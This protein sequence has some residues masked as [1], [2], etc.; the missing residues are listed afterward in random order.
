MKLKFL[1]LCACM[2]VL[3]IL[4]GG[5]TNRGAESSKPTVAPST[6]PSTEPSTEVTEPSVSAAVEHTVTLTNLAG[7]ALTKV[8]IRVYA[9]ATLTDLIAAG[10][11]D[12]SGQF[13]FKRV[14]AEGYVA[15][16]SKVPTGYGVASYYELTG[17]QTTVK[18]SSADISREELYKLQFRLG[19]AMPNFSVTGVDGTVYT[20]HELLETKKAVVLNFW[21]M[22][23]DPCKLEFPHIQQA[24]ANYSDEI[25][26]LAINPMDS[27]NQQIAQFM[28]EKGYTFPMMKGDADWISMFSISAFPLTVVIDRYGNICLTHTGGVPDTAT[29]E[30]MFEYFCADDYSQEYYKSIHLL[31]KNGE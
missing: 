26:L 29:F 6:Q 24:Y 8:D 19:D 18:L 4:F 23:C 31:P 16:L 30:N 25:A 11:T 15:V 13:T 9:D 3:S 27:N 2:V 7:I 10:K 5:C 12:T 22:G 14:P 20:L 28:Q 17:E 1:R 21:Y